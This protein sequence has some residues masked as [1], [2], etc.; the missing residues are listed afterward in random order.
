MTCTNCSVQWWSLGLGAF[1]IH[2]HVCIS[3]LSGFR[4]QPCYWN[5]PL[6]YSLNIC[7]LVDRCGVIST[8]LTKR[9]PVTSTSDTEIVRLIDGTWKHFCYWWSLWH[10]CY[11]CVH[12]MQRVVNEAML[13]V[14]RQWSGA[15]AKEEAQRQVQ[16]RHRV[17]LPQEARLLVRAKPRWLNIG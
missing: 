8:E 11:D 6:M 1:I 15:T 5:D 7:A 17:F 2:I 3:R 16:W 10:L 13:G 9:A 14:C 4:T 12:V